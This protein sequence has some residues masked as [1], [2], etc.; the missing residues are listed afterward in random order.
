VAHRPPWLIGCP[1]TVLGELRNAIYA[2]ALDDVYA[3]NRKTASL[4]R[5]SEKQSQQSLDSTHG[6]VLT[7]VREAF[8]SRAELE[9]LRKDYIPPGQVCQQMREEY[10][11]LDA[12]TG[13][14]VAVYLEELQQYID[15]VNPSRDPAV[16][17]GYCGT[18]IIL[19]YASTKELYDVLPLMQLLR[20][21]PQ[22]KCIFQ[23]F[24]E[25]RKGWHPVPGIEKALFATEHSLSALLLSEAICPV[26]HIM[27]RGAVVGD[28]LASLAVWFKEGHA[29][30]WLTKDVKLRNS[31]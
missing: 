20:G 15:M 14:F 18:I 4:P 27:F 19:A 7:P 12:A 3:A 8:V 2:Y 25:G 24:P 6:L 17:A 21:A 22:L 28:Y 26:D 30:V 1:N 10:R 23:E 11:P 9:K 29:P 16:M 31:D 13:S 5:G